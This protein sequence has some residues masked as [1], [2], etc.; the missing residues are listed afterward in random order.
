MA[1]VPGYLP[2]PEARL[3]SA[4]PSLQI[5]S[6]PL[7]LTGDLR[8]TDIP[9]HSS[10]LFWKASLPPDESPSGHRFENWWL[11]H[12]PQWLLHG[13]DPPRLPLPF[14]Y[15]FHFP[16]AS[17]NRHQPFFC[18]C[19]H[20]WYSGSTPGWIFHPCHKQRLPNNSACLFHLEWGR[21][22]FLTPGL[23]MSHFYKMA[24]SD[25]SWHPK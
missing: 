20:W 23:P 2:D 15:E 10:K 25:L 4:Y 5:L 7:P 14:L 8:Y 9:D 11:H 1:Y 18:Y 17:D 12:I 21:E 3:R 22:S 19:P 16:P 13:S 6:L 24:D